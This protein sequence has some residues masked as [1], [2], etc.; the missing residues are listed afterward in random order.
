[1]LGSPFQTSTC[2]GLDAAK[3]SSDSSLALNH[4]QGTR[5]AAYALLRRF[6]SLSIVCVWQRNVSQR[7]DNELRCVSDILCKALRET[8]AQRNT[9]SIEECWQ[10]V[11]LTIRTAVV[12]TCQ[13][14]IVSIQNCHVHTSE[15]TNSLGSMVYVCAVHTRSNTI[16]EGR[17]EVVVE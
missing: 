10:Q 6:N 2:V 7:L 11:Q 16:R 9:N 3:Y 5:R 12:G 4:S 15:N 8:R 13:R 1:M 17:I 14:R